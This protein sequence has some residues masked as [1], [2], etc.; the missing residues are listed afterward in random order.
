MIFRKWKACNK[1]T[2]V[3]SRIVR[4]RLMSC[5]INCSLELNENKKFIFLHIV[6]FKNAYYLQVIEFYFTA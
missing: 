6:E 2:I 4:E 3:Q 5:A 1:N